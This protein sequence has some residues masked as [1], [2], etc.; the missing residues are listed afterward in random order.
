MKK[1]IVLLAAVVVV[2][3]TAFAQL[4]PTISATAETKWGTDLE[5]GWNG[6]ENDAEINVT[7]PLTTE[8][9]EA[10]T[11]TSSIALT[12]VEVSIVVDG[13]DTEFDPADDGDL[14]AKLLFG[15]AY[16]ELGNKKGTS[17][18]FS[19][20]EDDYFDIQAHSF[21]GHAGLTFGYET[22]LFN[23]AFNVNSDGGFDDSAKTSDE[24][25]WDDGD[26]YKEVSKETETA[27]DYDGK[28]KY[29]FGVKGGI[30]A[31]ELAKLE[32][33]VATRNET[34]DKA[35]G[36]KLYGTAMEGLTY[37][38]PFDYL[39]TDTNSTSWEFY[40]TVDYEVSGVKVGLGYY[41]TNVDKSVKVVSFD[42]TKKRVYKLN[43][44]TGK[45]E[46]G[47]LDGDGNFVKGTYFSSVAGTENYEVQK[48]VINTGY[49]TDLFNVNLKTVL[50]LGDDDNQE[51][52]LTADV[53]PIAGLKAFTEAKHDVDDKE[54]DL[55]KVGLELTSDL[56]TIDNTTFT[57]QY[58]A[59]DY[60]DG[61]CTDLGEFFVGAKIEL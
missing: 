50:T 22:D 32:F 27:K 40:P 2:S 55:V 4:A 59:L 30:T 11:E 9:K 8:G 49:G 44:S 6:F 15:A 48:A 56:T 45:I 5:N 52:K 25:T 29:N 35:F 47:Y 17:F 13:D 46:A 60:T 38:I 26:F 7:I 42:E 19:D 39:D 12:G 24:Q 20:S 51:F 61:E 41:Q 16:V 58:G 10:T 21:E 54:T 1:A 14:S 31:S 18:N 34:K 3:T 57:I 43:E 28:D 23:V 33:G 37:A 53:T 36:A